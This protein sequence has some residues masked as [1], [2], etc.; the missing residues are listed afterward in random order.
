MFL[1]GFQVRFSSS[2]V[3]TPPQTFPRNNPGRRR[4]R[5]DQNPQLRG[6][7]G[8]DSS[9]DA[10]WWLA[11]VVSETLL[12]HQ[13]IGRRADIFMQ[14]ILPARGRGLG[15]QLHSSSQAIFQSA[16]KIEAAFCFQI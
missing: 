13:R 14:S 12:M 5:K 3:R 11:L 15:C 1:S 10:I 9:T 2:R 16:K 6:R 4:E 8:L 7:R